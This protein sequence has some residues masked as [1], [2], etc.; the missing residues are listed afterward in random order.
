MVSDISGIFTNSQAFA[1]IYFYN[2]AVI[3]ISIL[4]G[5][6]WFAS[7]I[8]LFY[9]SYLLLTQIESHLARICLAIYGLKKKHE[10]KIKLVDKNDYYFEKWAKVKVYC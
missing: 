9:Q 2:Y 7:K 5:S 10:L 8:K 4:F 6:V 3:I 1:G